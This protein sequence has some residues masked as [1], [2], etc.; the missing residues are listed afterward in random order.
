MAC[1]S[2]FFHE[3][4]HSLW[5]GSENGVGTDFRNEVV[6]VR[7]KP[8]GHFKGR[9]VI[10]AAS[11]GKVLF[12]IEVSSRTAEN[13]DGRGGFKNLV[14]GGEVGRHSVWLIQAQF[15]QSAVGFQPHGACR[16][17]KFSRRD[18]A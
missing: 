6:V 14:V 18:L 5:A 12:P 16:C 15:C 7:V 3:R 2:G 17:F 1:R 8:L 9:A 4:R 10:G 13:S 11:K